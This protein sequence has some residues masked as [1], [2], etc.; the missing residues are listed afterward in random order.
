MAGWFFDR[1]PKVYQKC[2]ER[3][4]GKWDQS[5]VHPVRQCLE[6]EDLAWLIDV[7]LTDSRLRLPTPATAKNYAYL[8]GY[9]RTW[10][11][12][13]GPGLGYELDRRG[14]QLFDLWLQGQQCTRSGGGRSRSLPG[15]PFWEKPDNCC[16]GPIDGAT[17]I[18]IG[19]TCYRRCAAAPFHGVGLTW[20]GLRRFWTQQAAP[21]PV[22]V[23]RR[24]WQSWP[25]VDFAGRKLRGWT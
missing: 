3:H 23:I 5:I 4:L 2:T 9:L 1:V 7:Y 15:K 20:P 13:A 6:G 24:W 19:A 21:G 11:E 25:V 10:W 8:L 16:A 17:W 12:G 22:C 18:G 14:W